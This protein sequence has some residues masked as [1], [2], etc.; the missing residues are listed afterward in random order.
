MS[1]KIWHLIPVSPA[2]PHV[3][4]HTT[5]GSPADFNYIRI[6]SGKKLHVYGE[7]GRGGRYNFTVSYDQFMLICQRFFSGLAT[8][9]E[10]QTSYYNEPA[11][12]EA[13]C[14]RK[15]TPAVPP[16]IQDLLAKACSGHHTGLCP[17]AGNSGRWR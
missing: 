14:G 13:P 2:D 4:N 1:S 3:S 6:D 10:C 15:N 5:A 12:S 9:Q 8:G 11:W 17:C 7:G 16:V